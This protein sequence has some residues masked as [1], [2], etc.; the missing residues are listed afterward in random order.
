LTSIPSNNS[1]EHLDVSG[2]GIFA[3]Y[4]RKS[5]DKLRL[6][7]KTLKKMSK[8]ALTA[9]QKHFNHEQ[10][11]SSL[12]QTWGSF[13]DLISVKSTSNRQ[14]RIKSSAGRKRPLLANA[15]NNKNN[16]N[17][18]VGIVPGKGRKEKI[19]REKVAKE[20][21]PAEIN[22]KSIK[23][24]REFISRSTALQSLGLAKVGFDDAAVKDLEKMKAKVKSSSSAAARRTEIDVLLSCND[25]SPSSVDVVKS[26][27]L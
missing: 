15:K 19:S 16:N 4:H 26:V 5:S 8:D 24:F 14:H 12:A 21:S 11:Q 10:L 9:V 20:L 1:I 27:I 23:V 6:S 2:N 18:K 17:N 25:I 7:K 22:A 3:A 13:T